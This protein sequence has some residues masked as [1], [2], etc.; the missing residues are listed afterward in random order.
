MA[1]EN[2]DSQFSSTNL[3]STQFPSYLPTAPTS[4][5]NETNAPPFPSGPEPTPARRLP[6]IKPLLAHSDRTLAHL[7]KILSTPG[8]QDTV[9]ST[10]YYTLCFLHATINTTLNSQLESFANHFAK[11]AEKALLPGE[12]VIATFQAPPLA[13]FLLR[14][15]SASKILSSK[16][17]DYRIFVRLW[18]LLGIYSWAKSVYTSP[19]KDPVL[20]AIAYAQVSA[21]LCFQSLENV[22]Y[23]ATSGIISR[24][25]ER[26]GKDWQLSSRFWATHVALDFIRL[27]RVRSLWTDI[28]GDEK[29]AKA[30]REKEVETWW[31]Q[32]LVDA[33]YAPMTVH[34]SRSP[35]ILSE[36][37]IGA[38]GMVACMTGFRQIWRN[39]A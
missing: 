22:A 34:Y 32:L 15:S 12:S 39:T 2:P 17:S 9:L 6:T 28:D 3:S 5:S 36:A 7:A 19:P 37:Q 13:T 14:L 25:P 10:A 11:N 20:R 18:G 24:K 38:L 23:L 8:G 30:A 33:C 26:I 35:G 4:P 27:W 29:E 16:I 1:S 31:R 21:N